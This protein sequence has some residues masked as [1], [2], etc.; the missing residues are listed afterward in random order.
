MIFWKNIYDQICLEYPN[1]SFFEEIK[2][3]I[4]DNKFKKYRF[5]N[6]IKTNDIFE[7]FIKTTSSTKSFIDI[8]TLINSLLHWMSFL[9]KMR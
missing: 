4:L 5:S 6:S 8:L 7:S 3:K 2:G 1:H 9:K